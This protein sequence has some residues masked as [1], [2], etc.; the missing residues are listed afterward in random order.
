MTE[1]DFITC[2]KCGE[3][4]MYKQKGYDFTINSYYYV[5]FVY[6]CDEDDCGYL[7]FLGV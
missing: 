5:G 7:E 1:K 3:K 6:L 2:K 4:T